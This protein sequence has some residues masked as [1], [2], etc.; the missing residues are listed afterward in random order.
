M[1]VAFA[2][3]FSRPDAC[4]NFAYVGFPQ[5]EHTQPRLPDSSANRLWQLTIQQ[6]FVE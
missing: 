6:S 2:Y 3:H 5:K 4:L 1:F